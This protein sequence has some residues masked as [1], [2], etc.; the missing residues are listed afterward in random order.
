MNEK[1]IAAILD[2]MEY[3]ADLPA[4]TVLDAKRNGIVIVFGASDDLME[5]RGAIEDE[6]VCYGG[7]IAYIDQ[8][9][10]VRNKC[11]NKDCPYLQEIILYAKPIRAIFDS[12][13][14][15]WIFKTDIPYETFEI[16]ENGEKYCRGIVFSM[17]KAYVM[18]V[19]V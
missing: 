3:G 12:E 9:G 10:L 7:G 4:A 6:L 13:G 16:L 14:Y 15:A 2:G 1:E 5:F 17:L 19:R 11:N 8:R 18:E